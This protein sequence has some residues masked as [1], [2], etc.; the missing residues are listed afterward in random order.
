[1]NARTLLLVPVTSVLAVLA[2]D[3]SSATRAPSQ[4]DPPSALARLV[5][6]ADEPAMEGVLVTVKQAGAKRATTVVTGSDGRYEFPRARL[7]PGTYAVSIRAVGYDLA[8]DATVTVAASGTATSDLTLRKAHA[9]SA[10]LT[11]S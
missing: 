5:S 7:E 2:L 9:L 8:G 4:R 6:S 1:M 10:Q 3:P 11:N